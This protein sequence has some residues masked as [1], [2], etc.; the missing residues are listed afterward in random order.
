MLLQLVSEV[1]EHVDINRLYLDRGF[2]RVRIAL[3]LEDLD[4]EFLIRAPQTRKIYQFTDEHDSNTFT[5]EYQMARSNPPTSRGTVW[6]AVVPH[7]TQEDDHFCVVAT[8]IST[9][10]LTSGSL[11]HRPK[12][13]GVAGASRRPIARP[14]SFSHERRHRRSRYSCS[15]FCSRS[16]CTCTICGC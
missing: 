7:R 5:A 12:R 3:A 1:R 8:A 2:Y 15:T 10:A 9:S 16:R 6:L 13:I 4:I 14:W 11:G